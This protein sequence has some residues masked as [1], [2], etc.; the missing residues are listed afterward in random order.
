MPPEPL[1]AAP[2]GLIT[3]GSSG[4]GLA[5]AEALL[6]RGCQVV[7]IGRD[8]ARLSQ[9]AAS[10]SGLG[11][12]EALALDV[13]EGQ[14][15]A[16][17][18]GALVA[19]RGAPDWLVTSAGL[20]IPGRFLDQPLGEH[21]AQWEANYLGTL[22]V[23]HA[24]A[25]AMARAGRGQIILISSA[26][27]L[28]AFCGY[29]AYAPSKWAVRGLGDILALELGAHGVRVLTAFPPDTDTPQLAEERTRR[30]AF[31]RRFA[32][33]NTALSPAFVAGR[34]LAAADRG[35]RHVAP[36]PGAAWLL[37]AGRPW[38]RYLEA[39]QRRLLRRHPED[40]R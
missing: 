35:R 7:I 34:I 38:A 18:M 39:V 5:L 1:R 24:L 15:V 22:H 28:G 12:V 17:A 25:P 30:P 8:A 20:A 40:S 10:L 33:G 13:R 36:G 9:T 2:W 11:D 26:A 37:L 23:V 21:V 4:I 14:D 3:G 27:A 29:S 32:A 19:R 16:A 31:T 6:R